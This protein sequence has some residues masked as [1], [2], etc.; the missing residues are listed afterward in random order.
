MALGFHPAAETLRKTTAYTAGRV[1]RKL[2]LP[3]IHF[4]ERE[5]ER[6]RCKCNKLVKFAV[7][8]TIVV[9]IDIVLALAHK[10][11]IKGRLHRV[12]VGS[13]GLYIII[14]LFYVVGVVMML[15]SQD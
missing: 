12:A 2:R 3:A 15:Y 4:Q 9:A 8:T 11:I 14:N 6:L 10:N 1:W 13:I 5:R 7:A